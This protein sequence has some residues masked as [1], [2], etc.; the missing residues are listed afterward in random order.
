MR[1]SK[2]YEER[3]K[4]RTRKQKINKKKEYVDANVKKKRN[5]GKEKRRYGR[6]RQRQSKKE[7]KREYI[8]KRYQK[9]RIH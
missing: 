2:I 4:E 6:H 5:K 9:E 7:T 3:H 8:S 1:T